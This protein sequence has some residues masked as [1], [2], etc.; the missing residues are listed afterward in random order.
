MSKRAHSKKNALE[1]T[2]KRKHLM[3]NTIQKQEIDKLFSHNTTVN[4]QNPHLPQSEKKVYTEEDV[5]H[6]KSKCHR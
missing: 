1:S 5:T 3:L 4:V 6:F 2:D